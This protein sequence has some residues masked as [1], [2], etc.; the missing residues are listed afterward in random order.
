MRG[1]RCSQTGVV[2]D[3]KPI[4]QAKARVCS[5]V[6][7]EPLSASASSEAGTT[8]SPALAADR[9]PSRAC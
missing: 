9:Q 2:N 7:A 6:Y 5:A 3:S 4:S 8:V 1:L